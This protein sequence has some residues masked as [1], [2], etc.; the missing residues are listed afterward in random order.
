MRS[1]RLLALALGLACV[2]STTHAQAQ[3]P[4]PSPGFAVDRLYP[5]A[6]GGGWFVMDSLDMH[7]GLGG[8]M[9][10]TSGYALNPLRIPD[11]PTHLAVV[12]HEAL[13][14]FSLAATYDR[15]RFYLDLTAPVAISGD[16]GAAS[17]YSFT[18]PSVDLGQ[19]PDV[20]MDARLGVDVRL[21]GE[22]G[23]AFRLGAGAQLFVPSGNSA[24]YE[25]D[26]TYRAMLRAL[27][28]GDVGA[29]TYAGQLGV[30]V[31]PVDDTP[32]PGSP[33][34]SELL[35]G[36][37][38][39]VKVPLGGESRVVLGPEIYGE[40]A[41]RSF[42]GGP[43]TGVEALLTSRIEGTGDDGQQLRVKL[44]T[45][46]GLDPQFGA[47]EWRFVVGLEVFDH[48]ARRGRE[49]APPLH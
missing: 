11:G 3:Q 18:A 10:I 39:G 20:L 32:T 28:A 5:S 41:L 27:V 38:G 29:F 6:A 30:H 24:D 2:A 21:I 37:A 23:A 48:A 35:F 40:T 16:S 45:G 13:T 43:T 47:P 1:S 49:P 4:P 33:Q 36:V 22:A 7:G 42:F 15:F 46:G 17:G 8:A 19:D 9:A 14:R 26:G 44:G 12:A 34:G 31:R 25:T